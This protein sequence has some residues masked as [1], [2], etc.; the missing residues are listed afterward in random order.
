MSRMLNNTE[1]SLK[2]QYFAL[3]F[4]VN[5][6]KEKILFRSLTEFEVFELNNSTEELKKLKVKL[7]LKGVQ[8][9]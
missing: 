9:D 7:I 4:R 1:A 8:V 5:V 6:L 3:K 2:Q